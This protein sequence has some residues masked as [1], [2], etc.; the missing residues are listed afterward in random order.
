MP[1]LMYVF[2]ATVFQM[3]S[4]VYMYM[5]APGCPPGTKV[6]CRDQPSIMLGAR[7]FGFV[8]LGAGWRGH[9]LRVSGTYPPFA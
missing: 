6:S 8:A 7:I 5:A 2:M 4:P 3:E 1:L 9:G